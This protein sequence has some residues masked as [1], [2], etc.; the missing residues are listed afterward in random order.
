M[1]QILKD[2]CQVEEWVFTY[3]RKDFQNLFNGEEEKLKPYVFLDPVEI[4]DNE[5]DMN[6]V[7]SKTYSGDFMIAV[8]SD[9]DEVSYEE[10][11][12]K[13]I[14]PL[15]DESIKTL[16]HSIRCSQDV[17]FNLW[18]TIE[19]INAL[20]YNFDGLIVKYNITIEE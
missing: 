10:R 5:N 20:D 4:E 1:Y 17:K 18:R 11:Y 19:V 9:I 16:K 8:S 2:I 14:K 12:E 6:V 15:I 3:A 7:E 13:Y